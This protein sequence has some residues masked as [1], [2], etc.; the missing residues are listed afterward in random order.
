MSTKVVHYKPIAS[1][2]QSD[3]KFLIPTDYDT[4]IDTD[5]KLY[6]RGKLTKA[7]GQNMRKTLN[8]PHRGKG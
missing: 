3:L 7:D 6:V 4:Y 5:L 8:V 1:I 2:D